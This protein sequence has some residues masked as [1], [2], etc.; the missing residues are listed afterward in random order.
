MFSRPMLSRAH[1]F[2]EYY[3]AWSGEAGGAGAESGFT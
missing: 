1:G 3:D 2:R